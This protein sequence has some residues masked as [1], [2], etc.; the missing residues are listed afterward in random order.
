M[1]FNE[2]PDWFSICQPDSNVNFL[3]AIGST[4]NSLPFNT[5][6]GL[7]ASQNSFVSNK[8]VL[9]IRIACDSFAFVFNALRNF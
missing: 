9:S 4:K 5:L 1:D 7:A 8:V 3:G 6:E 2:A